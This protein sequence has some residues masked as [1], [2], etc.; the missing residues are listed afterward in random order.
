MME[1]ITAY[2]MYILILVACGFWLF[3]RLGL[4]KDS[5]RTSN[6]LHRDN[7]TKAEGIIF[8]KQ[9]G[10]LIYSKTNE[11]GHVL[12]TGGSG[13]G[14]T[15]SILIPTLKSFSGTFFC[16]DISGDI[17][18]NVDKQNS[19]LYNPD[20][21]NS[22]PYNIFGA[23]DNLKNFDEQNEALERLSYLLMPEEINMSD[24][25]RYFLTEGRK[26]LTAALIAFYHENKDFVEICKIIFTNSWINLFNM[27]D[28]TNNQN[29]I[30]YINSFVGANEQNTAGCKQQTDASVKIFATYKTLGTTIRRPSN[31]GICFYPEQLE[32]YNVFVNIHDSK[33]M[34]YAPLLHIITAQT[35]DYF[36]TRSLMQKNTILL[37]LDEFASLGRL[38]ILHAL[39]TLRK[40]HVRILVLTQSLSDLDMI[41]GKNER[42]AMTNNFKYKA[43]LEAT[44]PDTQ[45]YFSRLIGQNLV[46]RMSTTKSSGQTSRTRAEQ[47]DWIIDPASFAQLRNHLI[48]IYP[49]GYLKLE[50]N[51][52]FK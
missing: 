16:I 5:L 28:N 47:K 24:S 46:L 33:L 8:G 13:S 25:S 22:I 48:L 42:I 40:K 20:D 2:G 36:S 49:D 38:D 27:I 3:I 31:E 14:K 32:K 21:A 15:S 7:K 26:I 37:C 30:A 17:S 45:D 50:K 23:I 29:A 44:D 51:Y 9:R 19:L 34:V 18:P 1:V 12:V 35:L 4:K 6:Q 52:W 11:E 43:V 10:K 41:Y 39:Q